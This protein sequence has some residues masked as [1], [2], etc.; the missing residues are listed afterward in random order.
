MP[1]RVIAKHPELRCVPGRN[2]TFIVDRWS[3]WEDTLN[4]AKRESRRPK[5]LETRAPESGFAKRDGR[6]GGFRMDDTPP[7]IL[8]GLCARQAHNRSGSNAGC[9]HTVETF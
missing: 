7:G 4:V 6:Q 2:R 1:A 9:R 5:R 8:S 3:L